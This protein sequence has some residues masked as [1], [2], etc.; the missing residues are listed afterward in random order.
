MSKFFITNKKEIYLKLAKDVEASPYSKGFSY[1]SEDMYAIT[2]QKLT[3]KNQNGK[4][5][6]DGFALI[7]GTLAWKEGTPACSAV[8]DEAY[9]MFDGDVNNIRNQ[10][11]G[12][13][14]IS[15]Y[16]NKRLTIWGEVTGFYDI[17]YFQS[18]G[19]WLVSN[20]LYDMYMVL[21]Q[22]LTINK[23]C[24]LEQF[25]HNGIIL[26][27]TFFNEIK[28]LSGYNFLRV[29]KGSFECVEEKHFYPLWDKSN[30]DAVISFKKAMNH[31][32]QKVY[33][34][35]GQPTISITGGLDARM[36]L[37]SFLSIGAKPDLYYGTGDSFITNTKKKDKDIS[38]IYA[39]KF[40]LNLFEESRKTPTPLDKYW[41]KYLN[42]FGFCYYIYASSDDM[43]SSIMDNP[44]QYFTFGFGGELL[45]PL[46]WIEERKS[47]KGNDS[48]TIDEYI[49]S[50]Y[51]TEYT[52]MCVVPID[53]YRS[54]IREKLVKICDYY[55]LDPYHLA[56]E[57]VFFF[58]L[59]RRK[60]ADSHM[61]NLVN[62]MKYCSYH[63]SQ[64]NVLLSSRVCYK[65]AQNSKFMLHCLLSLYPK[66]LEVPVFSHC[67]MRE[68]DS[69][70]MELVPVPKI[71]D[72]RLKDVLRKKFFSIYLYLRRLKS[73]SW[74]NDKLHYERTYELFLKY[75][76]LN[77]IRNSK[78][79]MD[80]KHLYYVMRVY[81][82]LHNKTI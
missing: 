81:A 67:V 59:E 26:G 40:N 46:S 62:Y 36:V 27:D 76:Y 14:A 4:R 21:D 1:E 50:Y 35:Y 73:G 71:I 79:M 57:D 5:A 33:R 29:T 11:A 13:Y 43:M 68:F 77:I 23:M 16:K 15:I 10:S 2:T 53:E 65:D 39:K 19:S 45:R 34:A 56:T 8:L 37:A 44:N 12:N 75:D 60:T 22:N 41:D 63:N 66:L 25:A 42:L 24:L 32:T 28:R 64:Y 54:Y 55:C 58:D 70:K 82:L 49:N 72:D 31:S 30:N 6:G 74:Y 61:L 80:L 69:S 38:R 18:Q 52:N 78:E 51:I 47:E 3:L 9:N 17:F 20:S 7:T 48:F